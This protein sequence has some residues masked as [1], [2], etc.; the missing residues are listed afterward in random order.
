MNDMHSELGKASAV[1]MKYVS[2]AL[3]LWVIR[4]VFSLPVV[5]AIFSHTEWAKFRLQI[6]H[7]IVLLA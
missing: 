5:E 6:L 2:K 1:I 4:K 3:A 7:F